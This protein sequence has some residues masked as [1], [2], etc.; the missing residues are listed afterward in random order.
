LALRGLPARFA[1]HFFGAAFFTAFFF[2]AAR[3]GGLI[4]ARFFADAFAAGGTMTL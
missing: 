2:A 3:L 4:G 1:A